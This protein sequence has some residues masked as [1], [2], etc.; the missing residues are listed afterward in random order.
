MPKV[1]VTGAA[2]FVGV[3]TSL[4]PLER[5]RSRSCVDSLNDYHDSRLK[6]D[7]SG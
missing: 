6:E 2:G 1:L 3:R 7:G 5:R 4:K